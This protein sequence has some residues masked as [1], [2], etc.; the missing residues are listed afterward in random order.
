MAHDRRI[1]IEEGA[2]DI[3]GEG[4]V[5]LPVAAVEVVVE[6]AADAAGFISVGEVEV[7]IA[8]RLEARI[9][10]RIVTLAGLL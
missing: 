8:P 2:A 3:L 6:D 7:A 5:R 1:D 4:E 9:V 10:G